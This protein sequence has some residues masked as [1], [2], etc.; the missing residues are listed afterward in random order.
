VFGNTK[1][2]S[3]AEAE[4]RA[5]IAQ[6]GSVITAHGSPAEYLMEYGRVHTNLGAVL[7]DVG[8]GPEAI[9]ATRSAIQILRATCARFPDD[10]D[11]AAALLTASANLGRTL[12]LLADKE[13]ALRD[14]LAA[15]ETARKKYSGEVPMQ[16]AHLHVRNNLSVALL[17]QEKFAESEAEARAC[18]DGFLALANR[19]P[20]GRHYRQS[21][22]HAHYNLGLALWELDRPREA[23]N[24]YTAAV[25]A[26]RRVLQDDPGNLN[27]RSNYL[28]LL[29]KI[30]G[31]YAGDV[32]M[33]VREVGLQNHREAI[34]F[35]DESLA[36]SPGDRELR[37]HSIRIRESLGILYT[38][39][40]RKYPDA[41]AEFRT[42]LDQ[43][44]PLIAESPADLWLLSVRARTRMNL[45]NALRESDARQ[46]SETCYQSALADCEELVRREPRED[47]YRAQMAHGH[48][49]LA[50]LHSNGRFFTEALKEYR[51]AIDIWTRLVAGS[52][53]P[54]YRANLGTA[55]YSA[56]GML[57]ELNRYAEAE[58][59][60]RAAVEIYRKL[61]AEF[62]K[63]T[64]YKTSLAGTLSSLSNSLHNRQLFNEVEKLSA[65]ADALFVELY[66]TRS[67]D[68]DLRVIY[69]GNTTLLAGARAR[70]GEYRRANELVAKSVALDPNVAMTYFNAACALGNCV[71]AVER[72]TKL[73]DRER[74]DLVADYTD[75]TLGYLR[76]AVELDRN[77]LEYMKTDKDLDPFRSH[78]EFL[79]IVAEIDRLPALA[80]RPREV[81][82]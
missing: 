64:S 59:D 39:G 32:L 44:A 71:R 55:H 35:I 28:S 21:L 36:T 29:M 68:K 6:L 47:S 58:T 75:R 78:P 56:G 81:K 34:K 69:A 19:F 67:D 7:D 41:I 77:A 18:R 11:T 70:A 61:V 76:S 45:G 38:D 79:K 10:R 2:Q 30:G 14:G 72:D 1:R 65:E 49:Q 27:S 51:A 54:W 8:R 52:P 57:N 12:P 43:L 37:R 60:L 26:Y 42:A 5:A 73:T 82:R 62:P 3:D 4:Y 23:I 15:T 20:G 40:F 63:N 46:E 48:H 74:K 50:I 17:R 66:T 80:P 33:S 16:T 53:T 22:A 9:A 31:Y 25:A 13:Q 24:E